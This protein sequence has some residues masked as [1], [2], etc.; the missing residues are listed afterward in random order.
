MALMSGANNTAIGANT[1]AVNGSTFCTLVGTGASTTASIT[2]STALGA[3]ATAGTSNTIVL[4]NSSITSLVCNTAIITP[5]DSRLKTDV[6]EDVPGLSLINRLRPITYVRK[7]A[8]DVPESM[9]SL[10]RHSGFIAQEVE[11]AANEIDF[12]FDAVSTPKDESDIYRLAYSIF[13]VP[14]VKAVQEQQAI[15]E[16]NKASIQELR[17][18]IE[19]LKA[20]L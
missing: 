11:Q 20:R 10:I 6:R 16:E 1:V 18:E 5:S 4:G 9:V 3:G 8:E 19:E 2:N 13:V 12:D 15:I 7:Q 14:L 17:N